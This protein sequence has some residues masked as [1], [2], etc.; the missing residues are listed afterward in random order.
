MK[1][2]HVSLHRCEDMFEDDKKIVTF[3]ESRI[4]YFAVHNISFFYVI[5]YYL[6]S[7]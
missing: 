2:Y 6:Q 4:I 1:Q 3:Y 5:F 7:L